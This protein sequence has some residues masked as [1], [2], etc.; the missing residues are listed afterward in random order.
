MFLMQK[1]LCIMDYDPIMH[2]PFCNFIT[3]VISEAFF[4]LLY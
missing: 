3:A 2:K 1:G 4:L